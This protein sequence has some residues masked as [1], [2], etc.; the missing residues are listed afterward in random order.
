MNI[1]VIKTEFIK[2][3][4]PLTNIKQLEDLLNI[5]IYYENG[6]YTNQSSLKHVQSDETWELYGTFTKVTDTLA[7]VKNTLLYIDARK[8]LDS[9]ELNIKFIKHHNIVIKKR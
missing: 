7:F 6:G 3:C 9:K 8:E 4:E 2:D 1:S 5:D